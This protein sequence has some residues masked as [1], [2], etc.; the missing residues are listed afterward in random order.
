[1]AKTWVLEISLEQGA[2]NRIVFNDQEQAN[3][4]LNKLKDKMGTRFGKNSEEV[5]ELNGP[6]EKYCVV[7]G[8][9]M[10]AAVVDKFEHHNIQDE[11]SRALSNMNT[12]LWIEET[13]KIINAGL[14]KYIKK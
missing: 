11:T 3:A 13:K 14:E 8:R 1:M 12:D 5:I 7:V 10:S 6:V 4:E 9:V 2:I